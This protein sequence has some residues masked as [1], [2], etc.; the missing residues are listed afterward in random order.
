MLASVKTLFSSIVDYAGLFP[1]AALPMQAAMTTYVQAQQS[2]DAW[3]LGH[4]VLPAARLPEFI[5]LLPQFPATHWSLSV[6]V[7]NDWP[8][9]I[10]QLISLTHPAITI[11][12]LE[13]SPGAAADIQAIVPLLPPTIPAFF[14]IPVAHPIDPYLAGLKSRGF[15]KIRT[16]GI[17]AEAFPSA[18]QLCQFIM[19]CA[20]ADL[21]FKATAGLHHPLPASYRLTYEP[22]ST[23]A[24]MHGFLNVTLLSALAYSRQLALEDALAILEAPAIDHFTVTARS[25]AWGTHHLDLPEFKASRHLFR[26]FGSCSFQEPIAGLKELKLL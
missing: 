26:S 16:G 24:P 20:A 21:P 13:F 18:D 1:P 2:D 6:I 8:S 9:T 14:E 7:T 5:A 4:F 3:I 17:T 25:I 10:A 23:I 12:A 19:A 15:A 22:D 11:A